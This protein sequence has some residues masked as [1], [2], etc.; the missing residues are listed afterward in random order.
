M[1]QEGARD[2]RMSFN[3]F[4]FQNPL[5]A[6]LLPFRKVSSKDSL[7]L[8]SHKVYTEDCLLGKAEREE[9]AMTRRPQPVQK[10][11]PTL[12]SL[13]KENKKL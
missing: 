11:L 8:R 6:D 5:L 9:R 2:R 3:L 4:N 1:P 10:P 13:A 7:S 12:K